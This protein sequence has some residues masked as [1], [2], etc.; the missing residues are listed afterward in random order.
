MTVKDSTNEGNMTHRR[1]FFSE[2]NAPI[3]TYRFKRIF[4]RISA[5]CFTLSYCLSGNS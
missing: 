1:I 4:I 3:L 5:E 2:V